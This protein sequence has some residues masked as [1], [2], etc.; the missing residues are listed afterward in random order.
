MKLNT[1]ESTILR[2]INRFTVEVRVG[3]EES[4]AHLTNTGRLEDIIAPGRGALVAKIDSRK[5]NYRL[6]AVEDLGGKY[7]IVDVITQ[8]NAFINSVKANLVPYLSGCSL[9]KRNVKV[10][11]SVFDYCFKCNERDL[12]VETKSAVM[13]GPLGE[14]M[15]PDTVSV[16]GR[17]HI[18]NLID[19]FLK[20]HNVMMIFIAALYKPRCFKPSRKDPIIADLIKKAK[21]L[22]MNLRAISMYMEYDGSIMLEDPDLPVCIA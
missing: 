16:R 6:I 11:S 13:R 14:A 2:R 8:T 18:S 22:G 21:D 10:L 9:I 7:C 4:R 12:I 5:L 1:V 19:L 20:G 3:G 17:R 15:Y